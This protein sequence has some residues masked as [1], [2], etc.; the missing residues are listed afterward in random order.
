[1]TSVIPRPPPTEEL[2]K[3]YTCDDEGW[4]QWFNLNSP[5]SDGEYE[6]LAEVR[7]VGTHASI[8]L[9]SPQVLFVACLDFFGADSCD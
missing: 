4:S 2:E 1:M 6:L 7:K 3:P 5:D 8:T 9:T